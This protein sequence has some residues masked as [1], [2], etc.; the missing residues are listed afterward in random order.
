MPSTCGEYEVRLVA[1]FYPF[2][3]DA[4]IS[5]QNEVCIPNTRYTILRDSIRSLGLE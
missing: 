3:T 1:S 5:A 4:I 2:V